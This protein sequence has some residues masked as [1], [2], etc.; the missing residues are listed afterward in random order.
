MSYIIP[1][2]VVNSIVHKF[3]IICAYCRKK[4]NEIEE[5]IEAAEYEEITPD[6]FVRTCEGTYN[7]KNGHFCCTDCYIK[8]GMPATEPGAGKGWVAP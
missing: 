5:Y 1:D 3:E 8:I 4:P 6:E 7:P 2:R